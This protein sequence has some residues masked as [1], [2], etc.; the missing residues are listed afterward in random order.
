MSMRQ[1]ELGE[2]GFAGD[3]CVVPFQV[4]GLDVRAAPSSSDP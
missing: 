1:A 3:D 4:E 2:F